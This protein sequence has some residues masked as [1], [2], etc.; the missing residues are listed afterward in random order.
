MDSLRGGKS[1]L[2]VVSA[3]G[4]ECFFGSFAGEGSPVR[5]ERVL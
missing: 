5:W 2:I 3:G 4:C 1:M